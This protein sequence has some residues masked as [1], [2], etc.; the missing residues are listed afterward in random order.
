M[1]HVLGDTLLVTSAN[2]SRRQI[3]ACLPVYA[4]G[5]A[6]SPSG[7]TSADESRRQIGVCPLVYAAGLAI[8]RVVLAVCWAL[9]VQFPRLFFTGAP[10]PSVGAPFFTGAS[11]AY[12]Y[13]FTLASILLLIFSPILLFTLSFMNDH[14]SSH[15][16]R[17]HFIVLVHLL[18]MMSCV[19]VNVAV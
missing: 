3:V 4:A 19:N 17:L 14:A 10:L 18:W 11:L 8:S 13:Y 6:I 12:N 1:F 7:V 16:E 5:S 9:T 15:L 2:E